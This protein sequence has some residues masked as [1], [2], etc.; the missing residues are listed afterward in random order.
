MTFY[1]VFHLK[2]SYR[3]I[4]QEEADGA[5]PTITHYSRK[6]T[7]ISPSAVH[8]LQNRYISGGFHQVTFS[9]SVGGLGW[10]SMKQTTHSYMQAGT[11]RSFKNNRVSFPFLNATF[12]SE[13]TTS[14]V[15]GDWS[16]E[17]ESNL[18]DK[19]CLFIPLDLRAAATCKSSSWHCKGLCYELLIPTSKLLLTQIVLLQ[20][21]GLFTWDQYDSRAMFSLSIKGYSVATHRTKLICLSHPWTATIDPGAVQAWPQSIFMPWVPNHRQMFSSCRHTLKALS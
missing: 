11:D 8:Q 21:T 9:P 18:G 16:L 4:K 7:N 13:L 12:H 17:S 19:I 1:T 14:L 15:P 5:I 6:S 10:T 2:P 3:S 20:S